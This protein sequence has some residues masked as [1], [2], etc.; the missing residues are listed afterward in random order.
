ME[1]KFLH[2]YEST[3][4]Y[5]YCQVLQNTKLPE[6]VFGLRQFGGIIKWQ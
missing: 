4:I 3:T 2:P 5:A 1:I 6:A